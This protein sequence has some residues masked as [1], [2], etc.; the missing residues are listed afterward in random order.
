[1]SKNHPYT[2]DRP[3]VAKNLFRKKQHGILNARMVKIFKIIKEVAMDD[4]SV[5]RFI[6]FYDKKGWL[7][8]KADIT[9]IRDRETG[10]M[11]GFL[12]AVFYKSKDG[13]R[14]NTHCKAF[15]ALKREHRMKHEAYHRIHLHKKYMNYFWQTY[16]LHPVKNAVKAIL[17]RI[18][19]ADFR[20]TKSLKEF[21]RALLEEIKAKGTMN[22]VILAENPKTYGELFHLGLNIETL[23]PTEKDLTRVK[24]WDSTELF[25]KSLDRWNDYASKKVIKSKYIVDTDFYVNTTAGE[26]R[27]F[28]ESNDVHRK[29]YLWQNF[30]CP[31]SAIE[32]TIPIDVENILVVL[33]TTLFNSLEYEAVSLFG[34]SKDGKSNLNLSVIPKFKQKVQE[35]IRLALIE[36]EK[37]N[38]K[39]PPPRKS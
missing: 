7:L 39:L 31:N 28:F 22:L 25:K 4:L 36:I 16:T 9:V 6:K 1:M 18:T 3:Y 13:T 32:V 24:N 14:V 26:W 15:H 29:F 27:R 10:D 20:S 19:I 23:L 5:E 2:Y 35:S 21:A 8:V 30:G 33:A 38:K 12:L 34:K 11:A 37:E 17:D